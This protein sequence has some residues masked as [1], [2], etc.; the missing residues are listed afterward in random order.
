MDKE[1]V[2]KLFPELKDDEI[3]VVILNLSQFLETIVDLVE[4]EHGE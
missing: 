3:E 1:V 2:R 4:I